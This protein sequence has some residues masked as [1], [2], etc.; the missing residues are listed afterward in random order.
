MVKIPGKKNPAWIPDKGN[1]IWMDFGPTQGHEQSGFR[2]GLV[3][4]LQK[5]NEATGFLM[6]CPIT[7]KRRNFPFH[8]FLK[9]T[10]L[11]G[12]IIIVPT[13]ND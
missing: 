11:E 7:S 12:V 5:F 10:G 4:S 9:N 13:P 8:G 2:P 3:V 6:V 1:M